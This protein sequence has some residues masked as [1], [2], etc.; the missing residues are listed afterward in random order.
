L[1]KKHGILE[2]ALDA[3]GDSVSPG[4]LARFADNGD[5]VGAGN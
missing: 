4:T 1:L 2:I 5:M 3:K